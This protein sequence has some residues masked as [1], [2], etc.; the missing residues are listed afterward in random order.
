MKR[1]PLHNKKPKTRHDKMPRAISSNGLHAISLRNIIVL[2]IHAL[3]HI[4]VKEKSLNAHAFH[5]MK[6]A[7]V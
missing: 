5:F 4:F 7:I 2:R 3:V 6:A 1:S